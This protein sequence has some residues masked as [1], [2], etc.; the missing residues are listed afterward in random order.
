MVLSVD[1]NGQP[2]FKIDYNG[3]IYATRELNF[4]GTDPLMYFID[5][6]LW[7]NGVPPLNYTFTLQINVTDMVRARLSRVLQR[8]LW[9]RIDVVVFLIPPLAERST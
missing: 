3:T 2:Y 5:M 4:E 9:D 8:L 1:P 6:V 7:D